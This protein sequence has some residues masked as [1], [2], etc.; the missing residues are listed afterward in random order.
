M[1]LDTAQERIAQ[2]LASELVEDDGNVDNPLFA[3]DVQHALQVVAV[4]FAG[5]RGS[6]LIVYRFDRGRSPGVDTSDLDG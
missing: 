6:P 5:I 4:E 3:N 1:R 2:G